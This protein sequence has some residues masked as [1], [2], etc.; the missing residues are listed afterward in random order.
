MYH[1][2]VSSKGQVVIP[3]P[4]RDRLGIEEGS[5]IAFTEDSQG[6][7]LRV[8]RE[9]TRADILQSLEAG[10]G[11]AAYSGPARTPDEMRAAVRSA[12]RNKTS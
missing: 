12:F 11:L 5:V 10:F 9:S 4:L 2:Q 7:H 8:Q 6:L 3:K 1:A